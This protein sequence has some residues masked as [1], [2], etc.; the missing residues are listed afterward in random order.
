MDDFKDFFKDLRDRVSNPFIVSLIISWFISNW[1]ITIALLFYDSGD[2]KLD[3][4]R[5][6]N[7]L[8]T[9]HATWLSTVVI[10][11]ISAS[12]FTFGFPYLKS[13]IKLYNAEIASNNETEILRKTKQ[14]S[15]PIAKFIKLRDEHIS[16]IDLL[17][18]LTEEESAYLVENAKLKL[19]NSE[20][21]KRLTKSEN[22]SVSSNEELKRYE[23]LS[24]FGITNG[25]WDVHIEFTDGS[26]EAYRLDFHGEVVRESNSAKS[27][28]ADYTVINPFL[29]QIALYLRPEDRQRPIGPVVLMGNDRRDNF[30]L[31]SKLSIYKS[32]TMIKV[33]YQ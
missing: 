8:I 9:F 32:F 30:R 1:P 15:M 21:D 14:G 33:T 19:E 25:V 4:F 29:N 3:G 6:F 28:L 16:N 12:V 20:L 18:K 27:W 13:F 26:S 23:E 11:L 10:P 5:S 17:N 22:L 2:V 7:H 31:K 24:N